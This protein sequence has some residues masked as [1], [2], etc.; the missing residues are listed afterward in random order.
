MSPSMIPGRQ[1]L[2]K[3]FAMLDT[4]KER[5]TRPSFVGDYVK[6]VE[7]ELAIDLKHLHLKSSLHD[8]PT[9]ADGILIH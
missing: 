6:S 5:S 3:I 2:Y 9:R 8:V 1:T 7:K 4:H